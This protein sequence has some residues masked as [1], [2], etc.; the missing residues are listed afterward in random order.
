MPLVV[1]GVLAPDTYTSL[2]AL[3]GFAFTTWAAARFY[4]DPLW[5]AFPKSGL[6]HLVQLLVVVAL[7]LPIAI[8][9]MA[10][11]QDDD[12][13]PPP[14]AEVARTPHFVFRS[15]ELQNL[16]HFLYQCAKHAARHDGER[17][18]AADVAELDA[19][20]ALTGA[21]RSAWD[22][23]VATYRD[24]VIEH[25]LLFD[26]GM[27][28]LKGAIAAVVGAEETWPGVDDALAGALRTARPVYRKHFWPAHDAANRRWIAD[29]V[30]RLATHEA[31]L[32]ARTTA[33][34]GGSWPEPHVLVDVLAYANWAGA[35][36]TG[37]PAHVALSSTDPDLAGVFALEVLFHE[38][39]HTSEMLRSFRLELQA[40]FASRGATAP[41][42][43]W[44]YFLFATAGGA[45]SRALAGGYVPYGERAG[46]YARG[47]GPTFVPVLDE[48]WGAF[49]DGSIERATALARIAE[50]LA[51]N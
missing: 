51:P 22:A 32:V 18:W 17:V 2:R 44:H 38:A 13:D 10:R 28:A 30:E 8:V 14:P 43:L 3:L 35:Y 47:P 29:A 19:V 15:H 50:A 45:V 1:F 12:P 46:V 11:M 25:D 16:H 31:E 48:H 23:A 26:D 6:V 41:R 49:L 40:A 34:Y 20:D 27:T 4:G 37:D 36:T 5:L 7:V 24:G 33:A 42:D 9:G 21:D 39:A